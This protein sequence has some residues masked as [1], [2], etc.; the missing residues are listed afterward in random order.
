MRYKIEMVKGG[1]FKRFSNAKTK[2]KIRGNSFLVSLDKD[3]ADH[4]REVAESKGKSANE[5]ASE[6]L[7]KIAK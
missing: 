7:N 4:I 1:L 3:K 2:A 6:L 5:Y